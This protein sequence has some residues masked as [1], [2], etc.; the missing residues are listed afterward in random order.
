[1]ADV[2]SSVPIGEIAHAAAAHVDRADRQAHPLAVEKV[3]INKR[4]Q[5]FNERLRRIE[6]S[7]FDPDARMNAHPGLRTWRKK[8]WDTLSN[9]RQIS[10]PV[11]KARHPAD[12]PG[13]AA[14][15]AVPEPV[16]PRESLVRRIACDDRAVYS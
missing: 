6:S 3:E 15:D 4:R 13:A 7:P 8:R 1:M 10:H 9:D 11:L 5:C 14:G 2:H 16:Q 12:R